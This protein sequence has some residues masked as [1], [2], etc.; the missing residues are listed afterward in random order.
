MCVWVRVGA[1]RL[2][3]D[4]DM[5]ERTALLLRLVDLLPEAICVKDA[6][7]RFLLSNRAHREF[8]GADDSIDVTGKTDRDFFPPALAQLEE[9]GDQAVFQTGIPVRDGQEPIRDR[10]GRERWFETSRIPMPGDTGRIGA[11]L[12]TRR[13]ITERKRKETPLRHLEAIY[14]T[15]IEGLPQRV[16]FKDAQSAFVSVNAV[17]AND[18]GAQPK[19]LIGKTD[20]DLFP[21]ELAEK[22]RADDRRVMEQ[23]QPEILEEAN[24]SEGR[25]RTVEV[26]K[27]PVVNTE[28]EVLG[29]LGIFTDITERKEAEQKLKSF[30]AKLQRSNRELQDFAYVASHDLQEPLRKVAVFGGRLEVKYREA[31]GPEGRDYLDRMRKATERMQTLIND[32]LS[33]ARVTTQ[34]Q[35]LVRVNLAAV[36]AEVLADLE[37]RLEQ[38]G[39][40][41]EI[42]AL[43]DIEADPLQMRQLFQNL[44]GNALKFRR[45]EVKPVVKIS[46]EISARK[47]EE[48]GP[49]ASG[50]TECQILVA[51]NGIGFEDKYAERIFQVFQRLHNRNEYAGS[52]I[53]LAICRKI[54]ERHGGGIS[55]RGVPAQGATFTIRLPVTQPREDNSCE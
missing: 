41:V 45:P 4:I 27:V 54:T 40:R 52:G 20:F 49:G 38:V 15:L 23:R 9:A 1:N 6:A 25:P 24:V 42:G 35:P 39:G 50:P 17:F 55:A 16:F 26:V 43:P 18:L 22:Y 8:L 53:G 34:A 48:A 47:P 12:C 29:L 33:F 51:D 7:G 30:A 19:D 36:V 3:L 46:G 2:L 11:V 13:D 10:T 5:D 28:D 32:L 21:R 37:T 44:I 14:H 31:L